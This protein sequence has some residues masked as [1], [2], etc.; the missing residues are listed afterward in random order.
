[1]GR[2]RAAVASLDHPPVSHQKACP[3][4]RYQSGRTLG[5]VRP[6]VATRATRGWPRNPSRSKP[7]STVQVVLAPPSAMRRCC[8]AIRRWPSGRICA[9]REGGTGRECCFSTRAGAKRGPIARR[10]THGPRPE[11]AC[12]FRSVASRMARRVRTCGSANDP[13]ARHRPGRVESCPRWR[14]RL[15]PVEWREGQDRGFRR[16]ERRRSR[17]RRPRR[18]GGRLCPFG[19]HCK[20]SLPSNLAWIHPSVLA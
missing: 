7:S 1:M 11:R 16:G 20:T 4:H 8:Q 10:L 17:C 15:E 19:G 9:S 18:R 2:A 5:P 6:T 3:S 13:R 12:A 14:G